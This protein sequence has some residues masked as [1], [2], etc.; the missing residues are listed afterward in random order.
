MIL[1]LFTQTGTFGELL[2]NIPP[3]N[4]PILDIQNISQPGD[5]AEKPHLHIQDLTE[6]KNQG[7]AQDLRR[8]ADEKNVLIR[9]LALQL[10]K[11]RER[12]ENMSRRFEQIKET[13]KLHEPEI[14]DKIPAAWLDFGRLII[15]HSQLSQ[16]SAHNGT[17]GAVHNPNGQFCKKKTVYKTA[18]TVLVYFS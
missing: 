2:E 18:L 9:S 3:R 7:F 6:T 14:R 11:S 16:W 4:S 15:L 8:Q 10:C 5:S 13:F 17:S 1:L 12:S